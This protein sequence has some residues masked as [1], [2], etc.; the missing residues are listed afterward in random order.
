MAKQM[1][2]KQ[3]HQQAPYGNGYWGLGVSVGGEGDSLFFTHNGRDEGFVADMLMYPNRGRGYVIMMNGVNG[4]VMGEI[5]RAIA[6]QYGFGAPP[7]VERNVV[8]MAPERLAQFQ[9]TYVGVAGRDTTRFEIRALPN[10]WLSV[11]QPAARRSLPIV[12]ISDDTFVGLEGGGVW[13][14]LRTSDGSAVRSLALGAG[15]N[16]RELIRQ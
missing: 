8:V 13:T 10:G 4:G 11:Y 7:R 9:G 14:F 6:E 12:P 3:V 16:R 15:P 1:V 2:S 5:E